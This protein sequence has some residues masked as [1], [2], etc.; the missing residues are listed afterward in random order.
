MSFWFVVNVARKNVR[1]LSNKSMTIYEKVH[2][3]YQEC[4]RIV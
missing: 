4:M 2:T 3:K 1:N